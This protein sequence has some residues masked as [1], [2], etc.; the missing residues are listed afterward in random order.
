[1]T[2][3]KTLLL[4]LF[5]HL[6]ALYAEEGMYPLSELSHLDLAAFGFQ[7][8]QEQI[9]QPG[10]VSLADAIVNIGGCTGSFIS[11][12]GLILTNHHCAYRSIQNASSKEKDYLLNGFYAQSYDEEVPARGYIVR[13]TE[14]YHDV[15]QE[16]L[17]A[18]KPEQSY[19]DRNKAVEKRIKELVVA[20]EKDQP[21]KRAEVAEMFSGKTYVLFLYTYLKDVRLVYAPPVGI[22][23]FGGETDNWTWPRH[24]GDFSLM[25][26]YVNKGGQSAEYSVGNVPYHPKRFLPVA[27]QGVEEGDFV[28][29]LGYPGRTYRHQTSHYMKYQETVQMPEVV[30]WY[31]FQIQHLEEMSRLDRTIALKL[32]GTLRGLYNTYKNYQGKLQGMSRLRLTD[33]KLAEEQQLQA[34]INSD[35]QRKADYGQVLPQIAAIMKEWSEAADGEMALERLRGSST[36]LRIANTLY[37]AGIEMQKEEVERESAY[38]TRNLSRTKEGLSLAL[39]NYYE[40]ADRLFL[41]ER[42]KRLGR[43]TAS[44]QPKALAKIFH[45]KT[46]EKTITRWL[47]KA[48]AK[49]KLADEQWINTLFG[50]PIANLPIQKEPLLQL[51]QALYED[52]QVLREVRRQRSGALDELSAK[53]IEIKQAFLGKAFIPDANGTFRLTFGHIRG[54]SPQ[55]AVWYAPFT[56]LEGVA[57]KHTGSEPFA[58]PL[59]ELDLIRD[60]FYGRFATTTLKSV[61]VDL[62]YDT[63]TTGGNSGSPVMNSKGE[64]IGLNFDRSYEATINDYAWSQA[65]SRSIGVDI[66]YVLWILDQFSGAK[67][68]LKEIQPTP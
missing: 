25:R 45:G 52:Y 67:R 34:Y 21:G 33:K 14:S 8:T 43:L 16:V 55:D 26:A 23:N 13:I 63:D 50:Q 5:L 29:I 27:A 35:P 3:T 20:A 9:F 56:T 42:I 11:S 17:Q 66:R 30:E 44:Q 39:Q 37:E 10:K 51:A 32:T 12:E 38:M 7:L 4:I 41:S 54:Y 64:L 57:Q 2:R 1:M 65:Y 60:R 61:P 28:F 36:L 47:D 19:A 53:L 62:L 22:G 6:N 68:L 24:T 31:G 15:S 48:Y 18:I 40:P 46:D 59:R 49:T 58:A